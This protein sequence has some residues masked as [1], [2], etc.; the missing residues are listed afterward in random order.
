M[1]AVRRSARAE[2]DLEDHLTYLAERS[3]AA[4]QRVADCLEAKCRT[5]GR[6]PGLGARRDDLWPGLRSASVAAPHPLRSHRAASLAWYVRMRSAPA[7]LMLVRISSVIL[8]SSIQP[9]WAA[10]LTIAY[11]PL[12]L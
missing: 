10:A 5:L 12:T 7:R 6:F 2:R 4:A 11:S 9:R 8:R 3:P 1:L